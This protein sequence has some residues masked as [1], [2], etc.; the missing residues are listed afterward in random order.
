MGYKILDGSWP[1]PRFRAE[2]HEIRERM[3]LGD[4]WFRGSGLRVPEIETFL[5]F[6]ASGI[7]IK[8]SG[9]RTGWALSLR[10]RRCNG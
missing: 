1:Y 2:G 7:R 10:L 6:K 8:G 3:D 4:L 9:R 5:E